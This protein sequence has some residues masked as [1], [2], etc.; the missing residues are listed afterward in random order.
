ML[1][2]FFPPLFWNYSLTMI[3]PI[4][5]LR[6]AKKPMAGPSSCKGQNKVGDNFKIGAQR[7]N[8]L[9]SSMWEWQMCCRKIINY[10]VKFCGI[11]RIF[12]NFYYKFHFHKRFWNKNDHCAL[13][14]HNTMTA[15][16]EFKNSH[17]TGSG[18][19]ILLD[20]LLCTLHNR[21]FWID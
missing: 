20:C 11:W 2:W 17:E 3:C 12:L 6:P 4:Q 9:V 7:V 21:P 8:V 14:L 15:A 16:S 1:H 5:L 18:L 19:V 10:W 13:L